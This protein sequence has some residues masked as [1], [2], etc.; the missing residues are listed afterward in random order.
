MLDDLE[1]APDEALMVGDDIEADIGGAQGAG[2]RAIQVR[3]GKFTPADLD[4]PT[5]VPDLRIE[6][7]ADLPDA[8]CRFG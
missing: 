3:T 5:V 8:I 4:H 1:V 6:T 2:L 7:L